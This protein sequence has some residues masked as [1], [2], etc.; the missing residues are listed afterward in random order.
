MVS[1][2]HSKHLPNV[3]ILIIA[4]FL[5]L[6]SFFSA[7]WGEWEMKNLW[8]YSSGVLLL[9]CV[10]PYFVR[11]LM[12]GEDLMHGFLFHLNRKIFKPYHLH[13]GTIAFFI[14]IYHGLFEG[15]CNNYIQ[16][17]MLIYGF[18][19]ATGLAIRLRSLPKESIKQAYLLHSHHILVFLLLVL[20]VFGHLKQEL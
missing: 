13:I 11:I 16:L 20:V 12:S 9:I 1:V 6:Y 10:L 8:R 3:L 2:P 14:A 17:A 18:L 15:R 4:I 5:L 7:A 19:L